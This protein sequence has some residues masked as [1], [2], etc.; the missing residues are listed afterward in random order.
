MIALLIEPEGGDTKLLRVTLPLGVALVPGARIVTP[1]P[2]ELPDKP[3]NHKQVD[4]CRETSYDQSSGCG[5]HTR[6]A[7]IALSPTILS[8]H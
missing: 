7:R 6:R 5:C 3:A 4:N 1:I 8:G 2:V